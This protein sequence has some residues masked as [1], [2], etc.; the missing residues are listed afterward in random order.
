[1]QAWL[2]Y[3]EHNRSHRMPVPWEQGINVEQHLREPLIRSLQKFQIGESG[4]GRR[5]RRSP[6]RGAG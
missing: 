6:R 1:M 4:E 3:Y 2:N 5:L